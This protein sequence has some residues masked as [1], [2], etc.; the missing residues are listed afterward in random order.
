MIITY[1]Y[2]SPI[3]LT[4][5]IFVE[6]GGETGSSSLS[7]R[8]AAYV[9]AEIQMSSHLNTYL[10]PTIITGTYPWRG[11][12]KML[13]LQQRYISSIKSTTLYC[14]ET[15]CSCD[16]TGYDGCVLLVD[17][18][19]GYVFVRQTNGYC[20]G[21][22]QYPLHPFN[23]N[24]AFECGLPTGVANQHPMLMALTMAADINLK[25]MVDPGALEGGA[26]DPGILSW[27]NMEYNEKRRGV[28]ANAF[29]VSARAAKIAKLVEYLRKKPALRF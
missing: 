10:L 13:E 16:L 4:D 22:Y 9:A 6:Y 29:G 15:E 18:L 26:G 8:S 27:G 11:F 19:N 28:A 25:E 14:A 21:C 24:I 7:Q 12:G 5:D 2:S 17:D 20:C 23:V 1:P 3:I